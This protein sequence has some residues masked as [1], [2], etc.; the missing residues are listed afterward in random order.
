MV[1]ETLS[2]EVGSQRLCDKCFASADLH[3]K[4]PFDSEQ[5]EENF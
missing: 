2:G 3:N 1:P 4:T 5:R